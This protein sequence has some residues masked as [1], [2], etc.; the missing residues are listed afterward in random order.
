MKI[1]TDFVTN[2]SS[3]SYCVSLGVNSSSAKDLKLDFWPSWEDGSNSFDISLKHDIHE[4]IKMIL[5]CKS[6]DDLK[7][8][9]INE[10]S[11]DFYND[12]FEEFMNDYGV[13]SEDVD[14]N[15]NAPTYNDDFLRMMRQYAESDD[16]AYAG[17]I[18]IEIVDEAEQVI[19][20]FR[21]GM[22]HL[23]S[24]EEIEQIIVNEYYYAWGEFIWESS[25]EFFKSLQFLEEEERQTLADNMASGGS[26]QGNVI[27]TI[28]LKN[29]VVRRDVLINDVIVAS[30]NEDS[31]KDL[32]LEDLMQIYEFYCY[33]P[34]KHDLFS[35]FSLF[36][37]FYSPGLLHSAAAVRAVPGG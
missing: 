15:K 18:N 10:L 12:Y 34:K 27:T 8:L 13:D 23:Q 14:L 5:E 17:G 2:S 19:R 32:F 7:G 1:R 31:F 36:L 11:L 28:D 26:F 3:S 22:D 21:S 20:D 33:L 30:Q 37:P 6:I 25:E 24:I 4:F 9:L 16:E 35:S 29:K